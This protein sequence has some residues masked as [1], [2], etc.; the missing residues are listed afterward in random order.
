MNSIHNGKT[1]AVRGSRIRAAAIAL[2]W[3]SGAAAL[4]AGAAAPAYAQQV[5]ASLRGTVT[6]EGGVSQVT[7]VNVNTGLTR[8]STVSADGR[9]Q[10][11]S[12]PPGTYRLEI[13][14]PNGVRNTDEFQLAVAQDGVFD[15]DLT[16]TPAAEANEGEVIITGGRIRS[17]EG[18]EVGTNITQR[19][20][21]TMPQNNRNFLAFADLAPGV[22]M[23]NGTSGQTRL[24]GGAQDSRTVNVFIDGVGQK[25][26]VLK[27]GIT[28]QD[29]SEGNP[30]PQLA[31]GEYR[32][33]SSNYKA[34]FDQVS[35][36]A[37]TAVTKS[38]TNDFKGE[39]FIDFT[40]QSLRDK[41]PN[42]LQS[43]KVKTK[44]FQFGG[45]LGGPIVKDVLHFFV[46]YEGKRRQ[47]PRDI[48]PGMSRSVSFFPS[49]YQSLFGPTTET[50]NED[51]Y[52]AKLSFQPTSSDIIDLSGKYR[53]ESGEFIGNG[54]NALSTISSQDVEEKRGLLRWEHTADNWVNEAKLTFEESR[55]AP[56]PR[57]FGNGQLFRYAAPVPGSSPVTIERGD[58]LRIGG[59]SNYQDK[60]QRGWGIQNDFT[61]TGFERHTI[62]AGV[63]AK[64]VTLK[65]ITL[66]GFNPVYSYNVAYNPGGGT[67][68]DTVPYRL[69]FGA[70][71]GGGNPTVESDNFQFG[72]FIQDD[73][74]ITDRLTL[75]LGLRWDYER[76]PSYLD[77]VTPAD[78]VIAMSPA[79][80]PNLIGANYNI[81]D[82]ISTGKER[83][84][85]TGAWQ[86]RIGF[87]Y[88][89]D[90][91]GRF[92]AFGGFGRSYDR[93]QFDFLR[94]EITA[95]SY[96]TRTFNFITGDPYI[97]GGCAVV[98]P[99]CRVWDPVYLTEAGRQQLLAGAG[100][101]GARE[102]NFMSNKLKVPYSDQ[103][104]LGFRA[105][106]TPLFEAEVGYSHVESKDGFAF[107]LG[108]R[109]PGGLF[110]PAA[111]AAPSSPFNISPPGYGNILLGT[112]GLETKA[113]S[114][115]VK[116]TKSYSAASPWSFAA[117]YTYTE[118]MEN[119]QF[120]ETSSFDFSS[121][122]EHPWA[123]SSGARKH[124]LV[125]TGSVDLPIGVTLSGKFQIASPPY[126][127]ALVS[128]AGD[129]A[130]GIP[131]KRTVV[132]NEAFGNGDRWG[133]RQMDLAVIKYIPFKFLSDESRLMVRVDIINL[134]NDY[135]YIDYNNG[136][137]DS[138]RTPTS[139]T[140]YR[141]ISGI[142]IGGN[143]TRT[144]KL[145]AGFSF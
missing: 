69:T 99:T 113:D 145:S 38:G 131:P 88:E 100:S 29:S 71:T 51:L 144:I 108:N 93:N 129:T 45:A 52:F 49:Q 139:P 133:F 32:V 26:Y 43:T 48:T 10:F 63:K 36:V 64:W 60:G 121:I 53:K 28:G 62:K 132:A 91:E 17:M 122:A 98:G 20:I 33:I 27:N 2:A 96:S 41:R 66:N 61:W 95:G 142:G 86:P 84:A 97:D 138:T 105:R 6:A 94:Q 124:R 31:V 123:R 67:F 8:T 13:T 65:S 40:N 54:V 15:F 42:E 18:G 111:P 46:T 125:A 57:L 68:N 120:G 141:E 79:N 143:P 34:E 7:V 116:L 25:D 4:A 140:I 118:A 114:A 107:L 70:A 30:F 44:D 90:E 73:W 14:T 76:T 127:K 58:L 47:S 106:V 135:N 23:V 16:P 75:N 72:A 5:N 87:S 101:G 1:N 85:F 104:S 39:A 80:Y 117:T 81:N 110:F 126:L 82:F 130:A 3:T 24:Q 56:T 35:S 22:Q 128:T 12:L 119:R 92:V 19:Q 134:F 112:N 83:K 103:F 77:F 11:A 109:R 115:Y 102:L 50:F 89:F 136:P 55:W 59:G 37:I 9:Y 78:S 74:E 21:A 137:A